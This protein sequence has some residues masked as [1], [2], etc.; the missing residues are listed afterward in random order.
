VIRAGWG[1]AGE[2]FHVV[3]DHGNGLWTRY[4]HGRNQF[5]V[6]VGDSVNAGQSILY[7]GCTGNCTGTHLH[8]EVVINGRRVNPENYV[9]VR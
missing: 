6:R 2:G 9:R 4:Y 3:I 1:G 5:A 7:M 8:F